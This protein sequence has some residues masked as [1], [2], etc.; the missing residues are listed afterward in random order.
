[1]SIDTTPLERKHLNLIHILNKR[2][3]HFPA[4][5][6]EGITLQIRRLAYSILEHAVELRKK[7]KHLATPAHRLDLDHEK[8]RVLIFTAYRLEYFQHPHDKNNKLTPEQLN[9]DR[10]MA[11]TTMID[12]VG[13]LI[14]HCKK[15]VNSEES[16]RK[17]RR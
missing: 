2:L 9:R 15:I 1:M 12:E 3:N 5:E 8:L 7:S 17:E 10:Y 13:R 6:R 14:G 4:Q 11:L 16:C